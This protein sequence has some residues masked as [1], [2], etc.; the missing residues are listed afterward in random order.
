MTT[1]TPTIRV[2]IRGVH[3]NSE[4]DAGGQRSP[5]AVSGGAGGGF[6]SLMAVFPIIKAHLSRGFH[7]S[8]DRRSGQAGTGGARSRTIRA[9]ICPNIRPDTATSAIWKVT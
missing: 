9:R 1:D 4:G 7:L 6:A 2:A 5:P 3:G 8:D